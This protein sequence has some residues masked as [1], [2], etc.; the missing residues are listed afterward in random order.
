MMMLTF[1]PKFSLTAR[2][3]I[4]ENIMLEDDTPLSVTVTVNEDCPN[5][6]Y[7]VMVGFGT[8]PKGGGD[9]DI[10]REATSKPPLSPG[11]STT[12]SVEVSSVFRG[13]DEKYC[14]I[15]KLDGKPGML[16]LRVLN[17]IIF[18]VTVIVDDDGVADVSTLLLGVGGIADVSTLVA[19]LL[20]V[21]IPVGIIIV[22]VAVVA[23]ILCIRKKRRKS[24][25]TIKGIN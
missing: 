22:L 20:G 18:F 15:I 13:V 25:Y 7:T 4:V 1:Q 14:Y 12:F 5:D 11:E 3:L 21:S 16:K 24:T 17:K 23:V 8:R 6:K 10:Q 9:C 2:T 19:V